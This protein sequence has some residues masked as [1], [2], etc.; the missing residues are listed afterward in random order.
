VEAVAV[1]R[2]PVDGDGVTEFLAS[3]IAS[4]RVRPALQALVFGGITLAGLAVLDAEELAR[5]L[6]LPVLVVNR[7][8]PRDGELRDALCAAGLA[9]RVALVE[10][11][12]RAF[13]VGELYVSVAGSSQELAVQLLERL[14]GKSALPEPL[15]VAHLIARALV[16]GESRGRP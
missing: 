9:E 6:G 4:L 3:W 2:F 16:T 8:A 15:R 5:R 13:S 12:P 14:R 7:K 1:T 10:R 11:L